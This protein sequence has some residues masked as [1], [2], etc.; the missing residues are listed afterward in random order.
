MWREN[1]KTEEKEDINHGYRFIEALP[2]ES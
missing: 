1:T 2:K